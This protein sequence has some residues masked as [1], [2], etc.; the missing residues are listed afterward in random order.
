VGEVALGFFRIDVL[1]INRLASMI[2]TLTT[3]VT[4]MATELENLRQQVQQNN[5][6]I[7]SAVTLINGIADRVRQA[8]TDPGALQALADNLASQ[9]QALAQAVAANTPASQTQ[10]SAPNPAPA[11]APSPT[12]DQGPA[13]AAG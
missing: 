4:T 10:T 2:A 13:P 12:P 8:Q 11:P 3:K 6:V 7:Q 5:N 9:D 1:S